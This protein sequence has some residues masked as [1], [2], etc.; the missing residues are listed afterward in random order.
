MKKTNWLLGTSIAALTLGA[1]IAPAAQA[2]DA[3]DEQTQDAPS[4]DAVAR[5][6]VVTVT[7]TRRAGTVQDVPINIAAVG[8][9]QIEEQGISELSDLLSFVPG[10]NVV[11]RGA[12][13]GNPIIVRGINADPIGSGDGDNSGGGTVAT[14]LGEVPLFIDLKLNDMERVEVLLGPQGTLYGAGTLAG[15]IRY[16]PVKPKFEEG[17]IEFRSDIYQYSEAGSLSYDTGL[18]VN[19]PIGDKFAIRASLDIL[20]DTGFVDQPFLLREVGVSNPDPDF[21]DP[22]AVAL[23]LRGAKDIDTEEAV[24]GRVAARWEPTNWLDGTL[25]YYFQNVDVGG[26]RISSKRSVYPGAGP[27]IFRAGDFDNAKRVPE[28]NTVKNELLALEVIADLGFAELTSATGLSKFQDDGQ[29]DQ[30]DLLVSLEYSY[31][32]FPAFGSYTKEVDET[33]TFTQELRLVS[34][35][36]SRLNWIIG[37]FYSESDTAGFSK[38]ITPNYDTYIR[39]VFCSPQELATDSCFLVERADDL[40]YFSTGRTEL[41]ETAIFGE[42]G[43]DITDKWSVTVGARYYDYELKDFSTVDFPLVDSTF[44]VPVSLDDIKNAPTTV[45]QAE[46]GTLFKFN[47]SYDFTSDLMAY[48]TVSEG[49]RIGNTNGLGDCK[50]YTPGAQQGACA[51]APGQQ[52]GPNP[53]DVAQFDERDYFPDKTTNY[54]IGAKT[55]WLGGDL[56]LNGAIF[57][58]EWTDP[59]V[60]S[61]TVNANIPITVNASGA[62]SKGVEL[63]GSWRVTDQFSLRGSY[64]YAKTE[65]TEDVPFLIRTIT[66][67]GFGTAFEDGK[68]GDR[69]PG[70][71]E[72]QFSIFGQYV[73]PLQNGNEL[74]FNASYAWQGDILTRTG[75]RGSSVTIPS[76]GLA[77]AKATYEAENWSVSLYVNNLFDEYV[78]TGF[79]STPLSNQI[80]S[81]I[82]GDPVTVRSHYATLGPP[83]TIGVRARIKFGEY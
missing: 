44:T 69:L 43:Y 48:F 17:T 65:L 10:I 3:T 2:Q 7:A 25:T 51:L 22:T 67:P 42:L 66:P 57:Y 11:D 56:I 37:G 39:P 19:A 40:E 33:E 60:A 31:E 79:V 74:I 23:N 12:R 20:D 62:E 45:T 29:R 27:E 54:E 70:S 55:A 46:D 34:T 8:A 82:N 32:L 21:T 4:E 36:D 14:Y 76:Y 68:A 75:G 61:A 41:V 58:V 47:T 38:E 28:P 63:Q 35:T 6:D 15:A 16:I 59:Q 18:T 24:S 81:D 73:Q 26:R 49:Y 83:R 30:N 78:E 5:Q 9:A 52:Y 72:S 13:Q 77:N 80:V 71:P 53:G 50:P 64:S 1:F